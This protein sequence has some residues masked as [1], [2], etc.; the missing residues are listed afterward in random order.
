MHFG[1]ADL[2]ANRAG[3]LSAAQRQRLV[4]GDVLEGLAAAVCLVA[5]AIFNVALLA[6]W[7]TAHGRGAAL[8]VTLM[9]IGVLLGVWSWETWLD[10]ATGNVLV[11]EGP[12][13]ATERVVTGRSGPRTIYSFEVGGQTFDVPKA[14]HDEVHEGNRRLYYLRHTRTVLS[15]DSIRN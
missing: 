3:L 13:R 9:V 1:Q 4:R 6:G 5:G 15:V 10:L 2:D 11:A 12:L 8:G 14:A 7:M